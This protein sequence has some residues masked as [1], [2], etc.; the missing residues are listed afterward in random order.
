MQ[1][2]RQFQRGIIGGVSLSLLLLVALAVIYK[3][4]NSPSSNTTASSAQVVVTPITPI[5][6]PIPQKIVQGNS[7]SFAQAVRLAEQASTEGKTAQSREDWLVVAA[8]WQQASDLMATVPSKHPRYTTAA[9]RTA[10][11]YKNS[12]KAQQEAQTK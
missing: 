1:E 11:Y 2:P 9:N 3:A 10:L 5:T 7:D 6:P 12:E 8:K 4:L